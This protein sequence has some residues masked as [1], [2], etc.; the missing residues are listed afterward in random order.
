MDVSRGVLACASVLNGNPKVTYETPAQC[1]ARAEC[2][3]LAYSFAVAQHLTE[4]TLTSVLG[5]LH[6]RLRPAGLLLMHFSL[7]A[8]GFPTE[9][10]WRAGTSAVARTR[11]RW[12]M[13]C[14]GRSGDEMERL[15]TAA[16]FREVMVEPLAGRT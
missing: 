5:L 11:A 14:F 9:A 8:D 4:E 7:V 6:A 12:G 16:G 2:A 10:A 3:D 1:G 15:L 13:S